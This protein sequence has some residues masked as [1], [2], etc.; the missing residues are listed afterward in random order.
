MHVRMLVCSLVL[1]VSTA[2]FS[3]SLSAAPQGT[4]PTASTGRSPAPQATAGGGHIYRVS[5]F[6]AAPG[7]V[8]ELEKLLTTQEPSPGAAAGDFA[9]VFRHRQGSE[10]D[11]MTVEHLGEQTSI[12]LRSGPPAQPDSPLSQSAAWHMDT[13]AAGPPLEEF[14]RVLNLQG[15]SSQSGTAKP[16]V[17]AVSDYV[18]AAGHRGQLRQVLNDIAGDT[19]G[20]T[21]TLTHV[22]GAPWNFVTIVRYDSWQQFGQEEDAASAPTGKSA[23]PD[24]G[25][26]LR[27]HAALHHDT[28]VT[29]QKVSGPA[30][31][32]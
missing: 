20:R 2:G 14:R 26:A 5:V 24:R 16:G 29:V 8:S 18:A 27:E 10:W 23:T 30:A 11:F 19:P 25:L 28:L 12:D 22:E 6:R 1:S 32:R 15:G 17:Y 3:L 9:V 4:A 31:A 21:V 7:R 13:F